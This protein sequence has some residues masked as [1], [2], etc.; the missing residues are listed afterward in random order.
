MQ[1]NVT[2]SLYTLQINGLTPNVTPS[3]A[4]MHEIQLRQQ[5]ILYLFSVFKLPKIQNG[6]I[7]QHPCFLIPF[8]ERYCREM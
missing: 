1:K 6:A 4:M 7:I 8:S 5:R 2:S 3:Q